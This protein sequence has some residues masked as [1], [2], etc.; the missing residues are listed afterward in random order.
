M[1]VSD[2]SIKGWTALVT[3][4]SSGKSSDHRIESDVFLGIGKAV[5]IAL[6]KEGCN[7]CGIGRRAD[8]SEFA[9]CMYLKI[10]IHVE[11][12]SDPK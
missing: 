2:F 3:G 5:C 11:G 12:A 4:A 6:A 10:N 8:V 1:S 9:I 7:I